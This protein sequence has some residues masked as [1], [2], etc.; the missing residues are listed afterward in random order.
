MTEEKKGPKVIDEQDS[1][2]EKE[3]EYPEECRILDIMKEKYIDAIAFFYETEDKKQLPLS[4]KEFQRFCYLYEKMSKYLEFDPEV[5]EDEVYQ[6]LD[7]S[8]RLMLSNPKII[9]E[10]NIIRVRRAKK[11]LE[12][13]EI[14]ML[15]F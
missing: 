10:M 15:N 14:N 11:I 7:E 1:E 12:D 2:D 4:V 9:R 13:D 3:L 6:R 8:L 5:I